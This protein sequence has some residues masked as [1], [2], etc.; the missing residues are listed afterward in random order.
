MVF[1]RTHFSFDPPPVLHGA[2]TYLRN[3][4]MDDY[5]AWASLRLKSRDFLTPWEPSWPADDLARSAFRVRIKRYARDIAD[6]TAY[7]YFI[8]NRMNHELIGAIT[9]SNVRRGVAQMASIG[10]WIGEPFA[11]QG[12]MTDAVHSALI[13][14]F[15]QLRLHRVEAAC[16]PDNHPSHGLLLKCG[17]TREGYA[18]RY[19]QIDG[20]W[21]DHLL[22][23]RLG[24]DP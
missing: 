16:L 9:I 13:Y 4:V 22:F 19:L 17:F 10:Y 24:S 12:F 21:Q 2:L 1:L 11:R 18:R 15:D 7:P 8:F 6:D 5:Q 23:A 3:P 20:T 14:A